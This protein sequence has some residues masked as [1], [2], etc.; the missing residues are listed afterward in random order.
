MQQRETVIPSSAEMIA[1]AGK[2]LLNSLDLGGPTQ[3]REAIEHGS[4]HDKGE[5]YT[6][7]EYRDHEVVDIVSD[8]N[9]D[10]GGVGSIVAN[11]MDAPGRKVREL[12]LF[13][14]GVRAR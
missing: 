6:G 5:A 12:F 13:A 14:L 9:A 4:Q 8:L 3:S 1:G 2:R 7:D 10:V 11:G